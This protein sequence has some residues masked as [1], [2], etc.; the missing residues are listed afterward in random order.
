MEDMYNVSHGRQCSQRYVTADEFMDNLRYLLRK[1]PSGLP[2]SKF[3]S[4]Y[5][6]KYASSHVI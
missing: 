5:K 4:A 1:F 3:A 2:I 6:V